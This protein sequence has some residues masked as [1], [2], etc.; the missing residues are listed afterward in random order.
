VSHS[1]SVNLTQNNIQR[2]DNRN[3][4][5]NQVPDAHLPQRLKINE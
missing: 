4:V 3:H 5:R 1:L 2:A